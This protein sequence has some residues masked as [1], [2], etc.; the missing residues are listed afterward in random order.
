MC[1][2]GDRTGWNMAGV[3]G[4]AGITGIAAGVMPPEAFA[5]SPCVARPI[6]LEAQRLRAGR[7]A[8]VV[9]PLVT[10]PRSASISGALV[11]FGVGAFAQQARSRQVR[12]LCLRALHAAGIRIAGTGSCVPSSVI[13]NDD[14]SQVMDTSD[15]WIKQ[16]T[17]IRRRHVLKPAETLVSLAVVAAQRSLESAG[18]DAAEVEMVILAT[19]TADDL[20]GSAPAIAS[21]LGATRAVAFDLTAACSGFVFALVTAAQ[22]VRSGAVKSAVVIGADCLSRWVDWTDRGTCILFGDGAGAITLRADTETDALLDFIL[23]SDGTG[24]CHLGIASSCDPV[25]LGAGHE[26]GRASFGILQMNGKE[27]FRFATSKV[28]EILSTLLERNGMTGENV[29]WLLLHQAN[30]RIM[31]SAAKRFGL[32]EE[33]II[34][35]LDEYGNT[36]AA[37]IPLALDEAVR[38]GRVK[39]G[40]L[41]AC[42]G[43]GAGLSWGGMLLRF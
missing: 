19:S 38:D 11:A 4:M 24:S 37:S 33:K 13:S 28:P 42:A 6:R 43:F 2:D 41:I 5:L 34:C 10:P 21:Q 1:R 17:G 8:G 18:M 7:S 31:D 36:S 39:N 35:N 9:G 30:R 26:G 32:P 20:F 3:V 27:V 23:G 22:Y 25:P 16:R 29:D 15:E 40:Q 14:L 12:R